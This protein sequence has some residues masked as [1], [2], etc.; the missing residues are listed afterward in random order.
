M[1][2]FNIADAAQRMSDGELAASIA[3]MKNEQQQRELKR[4][5]GD[6]NPRAVEIANERHKRLYGLG[7]F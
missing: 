3:A 2:D 4:K 5:Y 6:A 7:T 1:I